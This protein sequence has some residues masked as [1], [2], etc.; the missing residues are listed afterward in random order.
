[1]RDPLNNNTPFAGNV[2]PLSRQ[3]AASV[4]MMNIF[5]TPNAQGQVGY[6]FYIQ[7][8]SLD[9]PKR[10]QVYRFDLR[11][12]DNDTI[13]IKHSTWMNNSRGIEVAGRASTWGLARQIYDFATDTANVSYT[14]IITPSLVNEF[15]LGLFYSTENGPPADQAAWDGISKKTYPALAGL[16]QFAPQNNPYSLI[17]WVMVGSVPNG[18]FEGRGGPGRSALLWYD[19]RTP[20]IGADTALAGSNNLTY[21]RGVHTFKMGVQRE[22]ERF[23]QS[24]AG[25]FAGQFDFSND[26]NDPGTTGYA[27]SNM[28]VGHVKEYSE[29]LGRTPNNR[30]QTIWA[31]FVQDTWKATR[32]LTIDAGIRFSLFKPYAQANRIGKNFVTT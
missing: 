3:N 28:F 11:P 27:F 1:V 16:Q 25:T 6:N 8:K 10:Q 30:V 12:T 4:A 21:I 14:K 32:R 2:I 7:E 13:S 23:A 18:S 29:S 24:R 22:T 26:S 15:S 17:P 9:H 20:N 5:P 19:P 31:W